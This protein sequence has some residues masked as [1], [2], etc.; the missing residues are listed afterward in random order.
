MA[1]PKKGAA[2]T[3]AVAVP[4]IGAVPIVAVPM[5]TKDKLAARFNVDPVAILTYTVYDDHVSVVVNRGIA[6]CPKYYIPLT[7]LGLEGDK[8]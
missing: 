8:P 4:A 3:V 5:T 7:E 6:G 1:R 2:P